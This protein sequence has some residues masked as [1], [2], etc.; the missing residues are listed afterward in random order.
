MSRFFDEPEPWLKANISQDCLAQ[1][2]RKEGLGAWVERNGHAAYKRHAENVMQQ[3]D[4]LSPDWRRFC[5]QH[6]WAKTKRAMQEFGRRSVKRAE[7]LTGLNL[8]TLD[9]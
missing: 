7:V 6:G 8:N 3:V 4:A 1:S 9:L 2:T 5:H